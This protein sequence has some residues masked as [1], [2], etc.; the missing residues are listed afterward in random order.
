MARRAAHPAR[1]SSE[2]QPNRWYEVP[3]QGEKRN[4]C[5]RLTPAALD[6][7]HAW[8]APAGGKQRLA[9]LAVSAATSGAGWIMCP[10]RLDVAVVLRGLE[11]R[12]PPALV[13]WRSHHASSRSLA[14]A[15]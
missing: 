11:Q 13:A 5:P 4:R 3:G 7:H 6:H 9:P 8:P 14:K 1:P 12:P 2:R 15:R 10:V